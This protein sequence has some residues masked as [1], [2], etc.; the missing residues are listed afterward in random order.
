MAEEKSIVWEIQNRCGRNRNSMFTSVRIFPADASDGEV[1]PW[2]DGEV[3][4]LFGTLF[5]KK[6][7]PV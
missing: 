3:W 5:T 4:R 1:W 2:S 6:I 7:T